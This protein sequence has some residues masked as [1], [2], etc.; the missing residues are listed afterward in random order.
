M[1]DGLISIDKEMDNI[2]EALL[3]KPGWQEC[4]RLSFN[5]LGISPHGG[6][7]F[8]GSLGPVQLC[9]KYALEAVWSQLADLDITRRFGILFYWRRSRVSSGKVS[10][11]F[12]DLIAAMETCKVAM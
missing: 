2:F 10:L 11:G 5:S 7:R 12:D 4:S 9:S 6:A 8:E 1:A 3:M